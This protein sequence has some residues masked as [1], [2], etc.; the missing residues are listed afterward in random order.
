M[1]ALNSDGALAHELLAAIRPQTIEPHTAQWF[2]DDVL[3]YLERGQLMA[4]AQG[5]SAK[6]EVPPL[7]VMRARGRSWLGHVM[8]APGEL[9]QPL[10]GVVHGQP[11]PADF[12]SHWIGDIADTGDVVLVDPTGDM[13]KVLRT[14]GLLEGHASVGMI[15]PPR[16]SPDGRGLL[17]P[18]ETGWDVVVGRV[19]L[20]IPLSMAGGQ[21]AAL[22]IVDERW[23]IVHQLGDQLRCYQLADPSVGHVWPLTPGDMLDVSVMVD[24]QVYVVWQGADGRVHREAGFAPGFDM[25]DFTE[26]RT[27]SAAPFR[28]YTVCANPTGTIFSAESLIQEG[29]ADV[30]IGAGY[31]EADRRAI[32]G[33]PAL[34]FIVMDASHVGPLLAGVGT[35]KTQEL[36]IVHPDGRRLELGP[37]VGTQQVVMTYIGGDQFAV[38][39]VNSERTWGRWIVLRQS[40]SVLEAQ[41]DLP[42]PQGILGTSQGILGLTA[43]L[44]PVFTDQARTIVR[45]GQGST[46]TR[47]ESTWGAGWSI[48]QGGPG[49]IAV[50][51]TQARVYGI[52][53]QAPVPGAIATDAHGLAYIALTGNGVYP[54]DQVAADVPAPAPTPTPTP[55]PTPP[56]AP[57][58]EPEPE[59]PTMML[60]ADVH[61]TYAA[62]VAKFPHTG[63]DDRR[64]EM[65]RRAVAT[66]RAR[67]GV[68]WMTKSEH[69]TGWDAQST[70]ALAYVPG[71][72]PM[73]DGTRVPMYVW[74]MINGDTRAVTVRPG[75]ESEP[76]KERYALL[77][78][79]HDWLQGE[80]DPTDPQNPPPDGED[81]TETENLLV[82]LERLSDMEQALHARADEILRM[83]E[84]LQQL[85]M[86]HREHVSQLHSAFNQQA[87]A[88]ARGFQAKGRILGVPVTLD[89]TP[90]PEPQG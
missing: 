30:R 49:F 25:L 68:R 83:Q 7:T 13:V 23:W 80:G 19:R 16:F 57:T 78:V 17:W 44:E 37:T 38:A 2:E 70:D 10:I 64:R 60:P 46:L 74:D 86:S 58:P 56:P 5:R 84:I 76:L 27:M 55:T 65:H 52:P 47:F 22:F 1:F 45:A 51:P 42:L 15:G 21:A 24:D 43:G 29:K 90:K 85:I 14:A 71:P 87:A 75:D 72:V 79:T 31:A 20:S 73:T 50:P 32:A 54:L 4:H 11:L 59:T 41:T 48:G 3:M 66:V 89:V 9:V 18:T 62:V 28:Y 82:L 26:E 35:G 53:L 36:T 88:L 8:T 33:C 67:H 81:P 63:D 12:G 34:A 77:P 39:A 69:N 61:A 6:L 40:M